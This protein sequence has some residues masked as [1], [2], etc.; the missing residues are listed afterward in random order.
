[1]NG[2]ELLGAT[3]LQF[4]WQGFLI[5]ALY[6]GARRCVA[7]PDVRYWLAC[8]ALTAMA[9]S[10]VAT[11]I[12]LQPALPNALAVTASFSATHSAASELWGFP[13]ALPRLFAAGSDQAPSTWLSWVV[14]AWMTGVVVFCLRLFGGWVITE[15]LRHREIRPV[16]LQWQQTFD[17]LR[18]QL[19]VSRPVRLLVSGL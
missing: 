18:T 12:T 15:R 19:R 7:R 1:M 13:A 11:W 10:P 3:L 14:A 17:N 6:A 8:A 16:P 2:I 9:A 5:A 4:L